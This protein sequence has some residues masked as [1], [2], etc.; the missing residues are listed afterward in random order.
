MDD[1]LIIGNDSQAIQGIEKFIASNFLMKDLGELR[2][3]LGIE[4][5]RSSQGLFLSKKKYAEDLIIE[6]GMHNKKPLR[7]PLD[8]NVKLTHDMGDPIPD[9]TDYQRLI[10]RLVYLTITR[11]DIT[12]SVNLL[13]QFMQAPTNVH[14]Q[15]AKRILR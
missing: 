2:Y 12:Y 5:S 8:S 13:S 4:V 15:Q 9:P 3:F 7:L 6:F 10:G 11:P 14:M 1:L